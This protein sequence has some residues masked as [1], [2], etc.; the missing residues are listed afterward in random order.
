MHKLAMTPQPLH[1]EQHNTQVDNEA[2]T[3][4]WWAQHDAWVGNDTATAQWWAV[5]CVTQQWHRNC[6]MSS[7]T[8]V[9]VMKPQLLNDEQHN[10]SQQGSRNCSMTS[11]VTQ[12]GMEAATAQWWAAWCKSAM[13]PRL[14]N[15]EQHAMS[16][17]QCR[18]KNGDFD[19]MQLEGKQH[20]LIG[21][22]WRTIEWILEVGLKSRKT[23][24]VFLPPMEE[25]KF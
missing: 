4:Q 14:L 13:T 3:A 23:N 22:H 17:Q 6:S 9:S 16:Q 24:H 2:A 12:V 5:K 25:S 11:S 18:N 10:R 19:P 20:V 8:H 21:V 7:M 1:D 15:N